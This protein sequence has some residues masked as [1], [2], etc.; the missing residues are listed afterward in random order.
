[1]NEQ[2]HIVVHTEQQNNGLNNIK[3]SYENN[4]I[5]YVNRHEMIIDDDTTKGN[6]KKEECDD[7]RKE[8]EPTV[9]DEVDGTDIGEV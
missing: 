1:M 8:G 3:V 4:D 7:K 9:V 5:M 6:N 2:I